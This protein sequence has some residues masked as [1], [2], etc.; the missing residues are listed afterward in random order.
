MKMLQRG[1]LSLLALTVGLA[2]SDLLAEET[3]FKAAT[4]CRGL[5]ESQAPKD[6]ADF[7][8]QDETVFLSVELKGRPKAGKVATKFI[9]RDSVI[10][11]A[12]VDVA[13]VNKGVLLSVGQSTFAGFDLTHDQPL[14]V[15]DCYSAVVTFDGKPLGTFPFRIAPP[16]DALASRIKAVTLSKS[17]DDSKKAVDVTREFNSKEKVVLSGTAD[18]GLATWLE[19]SWVLGGTA[20]SG[21]T[22]SITLKEN[23]PDCPFFFS[24][25]PSGGWP[26]GTHEA[27]LMVNG[28]EAAREKFTITDGQPLNL[29]VEPATFQLSSDDGEGNAGSRVESFTQA[30]KVVHAGW[31]LKQA[32]MAKDIRFV[33]TAVEA[34]GATN[35]VIAEADVEPSINQSLTTTLKTKNGLPKGKFK[36]EMFQ[37]AKLIEARNFEVK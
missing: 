6:K 21:G 2:A 19:A 10:A 22:R 37:G 15:G 7:F 24:F 5:Q 12:E 23:K 31:Q 8:Q 29:T 16:K 32:T 4:F 36:V 17:V 27:V 3:L 13:T 11:A 30:D 28:K 18:L 25:I 9:F 34:D 14:P 35:E 26:S 1:F 33:W 20:D